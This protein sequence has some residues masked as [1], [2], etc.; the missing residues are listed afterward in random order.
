MGKNLYSNNNI[1]EYGDELEG[2]EEVPGYF[3]MTREMDLS[4]KLPEETYSEE[5]FSDDEFAGEELGEEELEE[6]ILTEDTEEAFAEETEYEE[7]YEEAEYEGGSQYVEETQDTEETEDFEEIPEYDEPGSEENL[8]YENLRYTEEELRESASYE[9]EALGEEIP[10]DEAEEYGEVIDEEETAY[11]EEPASYTD[12]AIYKEEETYAEEPQ[13]EEEIPEVTYEDDTVYAEES[14]YVDE[15]QYE[16]EEALDDDFDLEDEFDQGYAS[17]T[18]EKR[19]NGAQSAGFGGDSRGNAKSGNAHYERLKNSGRPNRFESIDNDDAGPMGG[20]GSGL[21][22]VSKM[23][24]AMAAAVVVL[25]IVTVGA[26]F[27]TGN[28]IFSTKSKAGNGIVK[29]AELMGAGASISGLDGIGL[30]GLDKAYLLKIAEIEDKEAAAAEAERLEQLAKEEAER[31]AYEE[32]ELSKQVEVKIEPVSILKD[33]KI[34]FLNSKTGKLI[35]NVPF[36]IEVVYP[37]GKKKTWEDGDKDGIIYYSDLAKGN[38]KVHAIALDGEDYKYYTLPSDKT[39][40]VKGE[41]A[42]KA[43]DVADEILDASQVD[44]GAEDTARDGADTGGTAEVVS[45]VLKD[46]VAY[47]ASGTIIVYDKI[48]KTKI[49]FTLPTVASLNAAS[50]RQ[51]MTIY[52]TADT[53]QPTDPQSGTTDPG[54]T[55]ATDTLSAGSSAVS[56]TVGQSTTVEIST[57]I[58]P[59]QLS[60]SAGDQSIAETALN[61]N[62][63][64]VSILAKAAGSTTCTVSKNDS[65]ISTSITITVTAPVTYG[66]AVGNSSVSIVAG[67]SASVAVTPSNFD[68]SAVTAETSDA[69]VATA[70]MS[71]GNVVI[72]AVKAGSATITVRKADDTSVSAQIAVTVTPA[73][74]VNF[75]KPSGNVYIKQAITAKVVPTAVTLGE[76]SVAS[77]NTGIATVSGIAADGTVTITGVAA[78]TTTINAVVSANP[79]IAASFTVTVKDYTEFYAQ[80][81]KLA[82]G[83]QIYIKTADGKYVAATNGDYSKYNEFYTSRQSYTGWQTINS[84]KY[85]YT[86]EG[87]PVTGMQVISGISYNFDDK[88]VMIS[89]GSAA[90][91]GTICIDVS[92][93]NGDIDWK[94]VKAAGVNYAII[95]IGYRGSTKGG[96]IDDAKF[97]AN[98]S[99]AIAAGIQVGAYFVTQAVNEVEAVEEAS[100][101][102]S[103]LSGYSLSLP[104]YLDVESSGG[105]GD[106]IDKAT[107]TAVCK[108]FCQTMQNSGYKAGIY[109]NKSWMTNK[110]DMSQLGGYSVWVAQYYKECTY[111]GSYNMWQYT[112]K[113]SVDG[114]KGNVDLS[115]FH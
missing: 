41:I 99:G 44:E 2:F 66:L 61:G 91:S 50:S 96:L 80:P 19:Y 58:D 83:T 49:P 16:E 3:E 101:A 85:Y 24:I 48:D 23:L 36:K 60:F 55:P 59:A 15:P 10:A 92:K 51:L 105:R 79:A 31:K 77:S 64:S 53:Q 42:Y 4:G 56:L 21:P 107:R 33:L 46:T 109:A 40:E 62:G 45:P 100:A 78:G 110:I 94:K 113:G 95:R 74:S 108:T 82:D 17:A 8:D 25:I 20:A 67:A 12:E 18:A 5:T 76:I 97:K 34:K 102:I 103:R 98:M 72:T 7:D 54:T 71:G 47:V 63:T 104:V 39:C 11:A 1:T 6:E 13:Y 29:N 26:L 111:G 114:I 14:Q 87:K 27:A 88:G 57:N 115:K 9:E 30:S 89:S 65:S 81:L 90:A 93:W 35:A 38:Y 75:D 52:R 86:A 22:A 73:A 28:N 43:I 69:G 84:A 106:A 68:V 37:D 112:D 70:A 32:A